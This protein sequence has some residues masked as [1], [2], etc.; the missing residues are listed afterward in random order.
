M[1]RAGVTRGA[2]IAGAPSC[3]ISMAA[4]YWPMS[5]IGSRTEVS[6]GQTRAAIGLSS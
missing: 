5:R 1:I 6:G 4:A 2:S 3:F